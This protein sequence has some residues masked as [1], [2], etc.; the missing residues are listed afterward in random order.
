MAFFRASEESNEAVLESPSLFWSQPVFC[1]YSR[2]LTGESEV[3]AAECT[4]F[5]EIT[6]LHSTKNNFKFEFIFA[7]FQLI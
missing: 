7:D 4:K 6:T 3:T 5:E 1:K 2:A